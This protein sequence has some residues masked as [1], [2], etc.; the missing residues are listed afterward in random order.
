[1]FHSK[2]LKLKEL[3]LNRATS[4]VPASQIKEFCQR[5]KNLQRSLEAHVLKETLENI[6]LY[7]RTVVKNPLETQLSVQIRNKILHN[8]LKWNS[9][10]K[11]NREFDRIYNPVYH[12]LNS[13]T[14]SFDWDA[15][16]SHLPN[17][18]S[19]LSVLLKI[20]KMVV[21]RAPNLVHLK[22]NGI[23]FNGLYGDQSNTQSRNHFHQL[24]KLRI[25]EIT[26]FEERDENSITPSRCFEIRADRRDVLHGYCVRISDIMHLC[27]HL[28]NLRVLNATFDSR[29]NPSVTD[30]ELIQTLKNLTLLQTDQITNILVS[31]IR[32]ALPYLSII[33]DIGHYNL[34]F[35]DLIKSSPLKLFEFGNNYIPKFY[36]PADF[37]SSVTHLAVHFRHNQAIV[38]GFALLDQ[39]TRVE[40]LTLMF[41]D[42]AV[43]INY[44]LNRLGHQ[45]KRLHLKEFTGLKMQFN[46]IA[47]KCPNLEVLHLDSV[48][49]EDSFQPLNKRFPH[50]EELTW[51]ISRS[52]ESTFLA[53]ILS[54]PR[55]KKVDLKLHRFNE[56]D[57]RYLTSLI[58]R[59]EILSHLEVFNMK[60]NPMISRELLEKVATLFITA[61]ACLSKSAELG[62]YFESL[63]WPQ[64]RPLTVKV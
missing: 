27:E 24:T 17:K 61:D 43:Y 5:R 2:V 36:K 14:K 1:M 45:L 25:L 62:F 51:H 30:A 31:K 50:L 7:T 57:L 3:R 38:S 16:L 32:S 53:N 8:L 64:L 60:L 41:A 58:E 6:D 54:M 11:E 10:P 42:D 49:I 21:S 26:N 46:K 63:P 20:F 37:V 44:I 48:E 55:L 34:S 18:S 19:D 56:E 4:T 9:G 22:I 47:E 15:L 33:E 28:P 29:R 59:K 39:M 12:L 35:A 13:Q 40:S 52:N 23:H